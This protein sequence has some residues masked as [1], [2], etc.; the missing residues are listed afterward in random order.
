MNYA[1][2]VFDIGKTNKKVIV[3]DDDLKPSFENKTYIG[4]VVKD[5]I[6]CDNAEEITAWMKINLK[7]ILKK[8]NVRALS[9]T[10]HGATVT[11]LSEGKLGFP[12][13]SYNYNIDENI[14]REFY[15]EFGDPFSLYSV[16]GT[17][18]WGRLL[19]AG[20]Q[21]FWFKKSYPK[22]FE[23]VDTILFYPQYLTYE[24]SK[25]KSCEVTSSG[26][27]TYLFDFRRRWWSFVAEALEVDHRSPDF[28]D[29]WQPI[30]KSPI[31]GSEIT[32][33]P[34]IHD[35]NASI[36]PYVARGREF[37]FAS[38]GTWC[39][40]MNPYSEFNPRREDLEQNVV[41]YV[42]SFTRPL[43]S[44]IFPGGYEHDH[45]VNLIKEKFGV[46]PLKIS[47]D[48]EIIEEILKHKRD[49]VIPGLIEKSGRF[50]HSKPRIVGDLFFKDPKYA[51]HV[52]NLSL[53]IQSHAAIK[54]ISEERKLDIIVQGGFSNN[55]I[56]LL[57]L[58]NLLP[59]SKV[60]K[61]GFPETT[62]L[63][64]ALCAKCAFEA[65]KPGDIEVELPLEEVPKFNIDQDKLNQYVEEFM[66]IVTST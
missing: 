43:K 32:F 1:I 45:Y 27:H 48:L 31:D 55:D 33:T 8:Y 44:L 13:I 28:T 40:F 39:V 51:Y 59:D 22:K 24:L 3:F 62:G 16:T 56:Y 5:S 10:T 30:G 25:I 26:C 20:I 58:S 52:L 4:E 36:L 2:V 49:F 11:Y 29:V 46:T 34:G 7:D 53:A 61:S 18:P 37:V 50:P 21:I 54:S 35:S 60:F 9:V 38:T 17:P 65:L 19:N 42:D 64:A 15:E 41:Y 6:L 63:G 66:N 47:P 12:I 23:K 57:I 14:R